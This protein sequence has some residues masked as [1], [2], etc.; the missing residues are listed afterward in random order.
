M[1]DRLIEIYEAA[2]QNAEDPWSYWSSEY[3]IRKYYQQVGI[4]SQFCKPSE[5]LEIGCSTGAHTRIFN[6]TFPNAKITGV[7]ISTTAIE[8]A[9]NNVP[10]NGR[11]SFFNE[12][13]FVYANR[14]T[15]NSLDLI[16][17]SEAFEDLHGHT[18]IEGF[19]KLCMQLNN[20]LKPNGILCI[21]HITPR[22]LAFP[23]VDAYK[24]NVEVFHCLLR[25]YFRDTLLL[26]DS[27]QKSETDR[28]YSYT[29]QIYSP[30]LLKQAGNTAT[31]AI[32]ID[33]LDIVIPARDEAQTIGKIVSTFKENPLVDKII[34]VDNASVDDTRK[35]AESAGAT[36]IEC[37]ERGYGR[38]VKKGVMSSTAKWIFKIDADIENPNAD[39]LSQLVS[40]AI[41]ERSELV[42]GC[43]PPSIG[44]PDRVT[45]FTAKPA[46]RILFPEIA[47]LKS[48]LS[49]VY[50][51]NRTAVNISHLPNGFA[52]DVA[53]LTDLLR[54]GYRIAEAEI[55]TVLHATVD[56]GKRTY[57]HYH[58]MSDE[59]LR[60]LIE[61]GFERFQ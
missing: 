50:L 48:P 7:D 30:K 34:V 61:A 13:I 39:W 4:I 56:N 10:P 23:P 51:F 14:L 60:Y 9:K 3:E 18:T 8:R 22:P 36:V 27:A 28:K 54:D 2:Y 31:D 16:V 5:I 29:V 44:D 24:K 38:A 58:R 42:K 20:A 35:V 43:W 21:S 26:S 49:G 53:M 37:R 15:E 41:R 47:S 6:E 45:N 11:V 1:K 33:L 46:L 17:W 40:T 32:S 52:F 59:V 55:E 57:E 12:D 19:S 25:D